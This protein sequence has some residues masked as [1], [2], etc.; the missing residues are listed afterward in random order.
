M[1]GVNQI[2]S[3]IIHWGVFGN[4]SA[5]ALIAG[6]SHTFSMFQAIKADKDLQNN[7]SIVIPEKFSDNLIHDDKYWDF[8]VKQ[9]KNK[10]ILISWNGNQHNIH[11]MLNNGQYFNTLGHFSGENFP[12]V[13]VAQIKELFRPTFIELKTVLE[14]FPKKSK[15]YL[16][17]TPSPKDQ[18][19]LTERI[20]S[21]P[22]F[23]A[24]Y[25]ELGINNKNIN[26]SNNSLRVFMWK[27]T[28]EM[29]A[30]VASETNAKFI[31]T[32][33][34]TYTDDYILKKEYYSDDLTHTN[35]DFGKEMLKYVANCI[36]V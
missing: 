36:K 31:P 32:P 12:F 6:H 4:A 9:G 2:N 5:S 11:F 7:F 20:H 25:K 29:A 16:L 30:Q 21:E 28:Q 24:L 33:S 1:F 23:A 13:P 26:V 3:E 34:N 35:T 15:I 27:I 19:F 18:V 8:V 14:R 17:G 10:K 22:Y